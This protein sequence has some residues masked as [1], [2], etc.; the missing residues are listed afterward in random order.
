MDSK[1]LSEMMKTTLSEDKDQ[2]EFAEE[3]LKQVE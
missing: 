2:R 1:K 3:Q